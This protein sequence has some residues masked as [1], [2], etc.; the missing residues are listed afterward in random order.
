MIECP[1]CE[2]D[3]PD[4]SDF[5]MYCGRSITKSDVFESEDAA[6][7]RLKENPDKNPLGILALLVM[8]GALVI[9]D[10]GLGTLLSALGANHKIAYYLSLVCYLASIALGVLS[11]VVDHRA[12]ALGYAPATNQ[13][14][15]AAAI[16]FSLVIMLLN[17]QQVILA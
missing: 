5:C 15:A 13:G 7:A 1:R 17:L 6:G 9:L 14:F 8:V 12:K 3:L 2:R 10:F 11:L 16:C 4:D